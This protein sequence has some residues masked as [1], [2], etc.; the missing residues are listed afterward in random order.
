MEVIM[1]SNQINKICIDEGITENLKE[2]LDSIGEGIE[3]SGK[4]LGETIIIICISINKVI[5][6]FGKL[7]LSIKN[8]Y[9]TWLG[10]IFLLILFGSLGG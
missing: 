7:L 9:Y 4:A 5:K 10:L 2:F 3:S 8:V 6:A 1:K